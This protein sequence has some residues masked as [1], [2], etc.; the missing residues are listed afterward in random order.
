MVHSWTTDAVHGADEPLQQ[1]RPLALSWSNFPIISNFRVPSYAP[2]RAT[3]RRGLPATREGGFFL[4]PTSYGFNLG[5]WFVYDPATNRGG[6]GFTLPQLE[7]QR[8]QLH[9]RHE[10]HALASRSTPGRP[11][12]A[13]AAPSTTVPN[14]P[15]EVALI[16]DS[17]VK[18]SA[19]AGDRGRHRPHGVG[20]RPLPSQWFHHDAHAEHAGGLRLFRRDLQLRFQL[21]AG[22]GAARRRRAAAVL[23]SRSFHPGLVNSVLV[24]GAVKSFSDNIAL[25]VW[26]GLGTRAGGEKLSEFLRGRLR[27]GAPSLPTQR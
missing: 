8:R 18:R 6:D 10:Q 27:Q 20:E 13:T 1:D 12:P 17:G 23:T 15:P 19:P 16:A 22:G 14:T 11:T 3:P 5:T 7:P 26:R 4:L 2:A 9:R 25:D 24:D 21:A